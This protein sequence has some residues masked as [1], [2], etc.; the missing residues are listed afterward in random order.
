[1]LDSVI[2]PNKL[3]PVFKP[4]VHRAIKSVS[5]FA[6]VSRNRLQNLARLLHVVDRDGVHGEIVETGIAR[7]GSVV[8]LAMLTAQSNIKRRVWGYDAFELFGQEGAG[9]YDE[10][11][12]T[13]RERFGFGE[14]DVKVIKGFFDDTL[15]AYPGDPI[16]FCHIDASAYEP[17]KT[18]IERLYPFVQPRGMVV[19]DNYG[20]DE[21]C[22]RAVDKFLEKHNLAGLLNRFGHT[23]A[24]FRKPKQG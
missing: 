20:A 13:I 2:I 21:G 16:A 15:P 24:W 11:C 9:V 23:Q 17:I 14:A 22:R 10:V 19:F 1:M 5:S 4:G 8:F 6:M 18:C 3:V 7:G 12:A